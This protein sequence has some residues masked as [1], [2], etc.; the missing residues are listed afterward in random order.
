M[1]VDWVRVLLKLLIILSKISEKIHYNLKSN[2]NGLIVMDLK[3][4]W[5]HVE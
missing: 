1:D 5:Y 4:L 2:D 3:W